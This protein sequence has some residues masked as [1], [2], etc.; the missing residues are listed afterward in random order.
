MYYHKMEINKQQ[1]KSKDMT[2][3]NFILMIIL[4]LGTITLSAQ[5]TKKD[6]ET[7]KEK[8]VQTFVFSFDS[9]ELGDKLDKALAKV[10]S[11]DKDL[12]N[13]R[14]TEFKFKMG[15]LKE[16]M[17]DLKLKIGDF[18]NSKVKIWS[19]DANVFTF[20][21]NDNDQDPASLFD[22]LSKY[23][24]ISSIYISKSM[25]NLVG[26]M[27]LNMGDMNVKDVSKKLDQIEI[28]TA[29]DSKT[30][31]YMSY[32]IS[33]VKKNK[34][35]E[36][37]M[38]VKKDGEDMTFYGVK[39]KKN[40]KEMIMITSKKEKGVIIRMVGNFTIDDIQKV[41]KKADK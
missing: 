37:L 32:E 39:D 19:D 18:E 2:K 12:L 34:D 11:I 7:S 5:D 28:Y 13:K 3:N 4:L 40:F 27:N 22:R 1:I 17:G 15:D 31:K 25:L 14:M 21:I 26:D 24:G 10:E 33:K 20:S 36:L 35:Y 30:M 41:A 6:N 38:N 8:K 23:K 9:K 16:K 29:T